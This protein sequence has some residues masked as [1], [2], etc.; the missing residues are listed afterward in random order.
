MSLPLTTGGFR[1]AEVARQSA[2]IR[3][4][5]YRREDALQGVEQAILNALNAIGFSHPNIRL[6]REALEAAE[7]HYRSSEELYSQG[8]ASLVD[9]LDAQTAL[10]RQKQE[11]SVAAY[12]Y[13]ADVFALQ[14]AIAWFEFEK[15]A[16]DKKWFDRNLQHFLRG[17]SITTA[18]G[19]LL[20]TGFE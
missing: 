2:L 18:K 9:L 5:T 16:E 7:A 15:N 1:T 20:Q 13:L 6:T 14:R 10:I 17:G 19:H 12:A 11:S 8:A 4:T 3:Q